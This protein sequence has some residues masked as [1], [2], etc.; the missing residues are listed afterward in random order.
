MPE[1]KLDERLNVYREINVPPETMYLGL[2]WDD[3]PETKK[4]HYRRFYTQELE[5][6]KEV[7]PV[8][9]PFAS[10]DIMRGQSRGASQTWWPFGS[11]PK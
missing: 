9:S 6:V 4:R 2:G 10:F 7:M 5:T 8:V 11:A 3:K 1:Y